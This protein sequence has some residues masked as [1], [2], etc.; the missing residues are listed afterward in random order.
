MLDGRVCF[1]TRYDQL[2]NRSEMHTGEKVGEALRTK[3]D[4]LF[5]V[6]EMQAGERV[7]EGPAGKYWYEAI[8]TA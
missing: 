8:P 7:C 5:V 3:H 2:P 4:Q 6:S 1:N